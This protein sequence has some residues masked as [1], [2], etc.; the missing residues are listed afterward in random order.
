M[1]SDEIYKEGAM[2]MVLSGLES[3]KALDGLGPEDAGD[4]HASRR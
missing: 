1:N 3:P 4:F 2:T